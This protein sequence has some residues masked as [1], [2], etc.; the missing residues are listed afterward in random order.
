VSPRKPVA[1]SAGPMTLGSLP[2]NLRA[3]MSLLAKKFQKDKS[4]MTYHLVDINP[5]ERERHLQEAYDV[6]FKRVL[7]NYKLRK[8]NYGK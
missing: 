6:I 7:K 2:R 5:V 4:K 3:F 1:F 8:N